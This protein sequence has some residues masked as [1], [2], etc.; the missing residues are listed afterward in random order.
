MWFTDFSSPGT[1]GGIPRH[2][3][4]D[5]CCRST[6]RLLPVL[7]VTSRAPPWQHPGWDLVQ[8]VE[9]VWW[10]DSRRIWRSVS[11]MTASVL[12]AFAA[13]L[14]LVR[15]EQKFN[16]EGFENSS[17]LQS[18][19]K[20]GWMPPILLQ[21]PPPPPGLSSQLPLLLCRRAL[22][23]PTNWKVERVFIISLKNLSGGWR[24]S[25]V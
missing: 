6:D 5:V 2:G 14:A 20:L 12:L 3:R 17:D 8:T 19:W 10:Q 25:S 24:C 18:I 23:Q 22:V 11:T 4:V 9:F 13:S 1:V 21:Q 7:V 16:A 15:V